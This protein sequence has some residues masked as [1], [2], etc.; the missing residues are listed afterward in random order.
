MYS[1]DNKHD[2]PFSAS[3]FN[4]ALVLPGMKVILGMQERSQLC[5]TLVMYCLLLLCQELFKIRIM[6]NS[7]VLILEIGLLRFASKRPPSP[8][9]WDRS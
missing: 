6:S 7:D 3:F 9:V 1:H 2:T 8:L 4:T 5:K